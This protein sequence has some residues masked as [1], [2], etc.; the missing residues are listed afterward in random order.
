MSKQWQS[1]FPGQG[2]VQKG[3]MTHLDYAM[4]YADADLPQYRPL[5]GQVQ[6]ELRQIPLPQRVYMNF[7]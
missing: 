5:V 4:K 1:A 2:D 6:Q 3:L 7:R